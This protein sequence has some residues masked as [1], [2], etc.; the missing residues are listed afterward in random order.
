M[1]NW[2]NILPPAFVPNT[3]YCINRVV[4]AAE[5]DLS[6][7]NNQSGDPISMPFQVGFSASVELSISGNPASNVT[8]VVAQTDFG[9]GVWYDVCGC[10]WTGASGTANFF[11][12][13]GV[14]GANVLQQT[15]TSGQDPGANFSNQIVLGG[16]LRFVGK[17]VLTSQAAQGA[18]SSSSS[19]SSAGPGPVQQVTATI[20]Y[21]LIPLN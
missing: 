2:A 3:A 12:S 10:R 9:D 4:P 19:S 15:R 20:R 21:N 14:S 16:R 7:S 11:L 17:S 8:Y 13:G 6:D 18:S 5:G 1:P